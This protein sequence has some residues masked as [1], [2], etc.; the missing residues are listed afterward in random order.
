V[1]ADDDEENFG[2]LLRGYRLSANLTQEDLASR[3]GLS[4]RTISNLEARRTGR[5]YRRTVELL[6]DALRLSEDGRA[7]LISAARGAPPVQTQTEAE[8]ETEGSPAFRPA[9]LP[10]DIAEFTGRAEQVDWVTGF[11]GGTEGPRPVKVAAVTGAGGLGKSALALHVAHRLSGVFP[12][13]Q[14]F[15]DLQSSGDQPVSAGEALARLLRHLGMA[16]AAVPGDVAERAAEF[17]TRMAGLSMLLVLDDARDAAHVRPLLP[18]GAPSAVLITSRGWLADLEGARVLALEALDHADARNLFATICGPERVA[19]EPEATDAVLEVCGGLPLA[20]RIAAARL[21]SR[22]GWQVASLARRLDDERHRLEELQVGDLAVRACFHVSYSALRQSAAPADDVSRA[23][24][25]LGLWPGT[26]ISLAAA[27]ALLGIDDRAASAL[28]ERLVD[29]HMIESPALYRYRFHDLIRVFAAERAQFDELPELREQA[30]KRVLLWYLH[31]AADAFSVIGL[32]PRRASVPDAEPGIRSPGFGD[33]A[34]ATS[35][36]D[37]E[38]DNLVSAVTLAKASDLDELCVWLADVTWQNF[39]RTPWDGWIGVLDLG[40]SSAAAIGDASAEAWLRNYVGVTSMYR[41]LFQDAVGHFR[42]ALPL[43]VQAGDLNCEVT[44]TA[45]LGTAY[46][47]LRRFDESIAQFERSLAADPDQPHLGQ[48]MVNLGMAYVEAGRAE[49]G[50]DRLEAGLAAIR[51]AGDSWG[52]SFARSGL[53]EGYRA[54]GR[55]EDAIRQAEQALAFG[56]KFRNDYQELFALNTLGE[57]LADYGDLE[58]ARSCLISAR[59]LAEKFGVPELER[60]TASLA[61][62]ENARADRNLA[63]PIPARTFP[64]RLRGPRLTARTSW[65]SRGKPKGSGNQRARLIRDG[66]S[67]PASGPAGQPAGSLRSGPGEDRAEP[68]QLRGGAAERELVAFRGGEVAVQGM[69]DV[70]AYPAV[71]VDG[72]V[73]DPVTA[74]GGPELRGRDLGLGGQAGFQPPRGLPHGQPDRLDVDVS[75]GQ[76]LRHG[77]ERADGPAEGLAALGVLGGLLERPLGHAELQRAEPGRR[78]VEQPGKHL[79]VR[80][81]DQ[82]VIADLDVGEAEPR[83]TGPV[84]ESLRLDFDPAVLALDR[85]DGGAFR[86]RSADQ[87]QAGDRPER[88]CGLGAVQAPA[89]ARALGAGTRTD[90]VVADGFGEGG[91]DDQLTTCGC[92]CVTIWMIGKG[93]RAEHDGFQVGSGCEGAPELDQDRALL[94]QPVAVAADAFRQRGGEDAG[95]GQVGP[96]RFVE[97]AARALELGQPVG[98]QP[99]GQDPAAQR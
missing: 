85:E 86:C 75:V 78:P 6:A 96:D 54:L 59:Q 25:L 88:H 94:G 81:A 91:G 63:G 53:A 80:R 56:R 68:E 30:R 84:D 46:K 45:N 55:Y 37:T 14:L 97:A 32:R 74:V 15:V 87:E 34:A 57:V 95:R 24:R 99:V 62:I 64:V 33:Q 18:G 82:P 69:A 16:D 40:M 29:V 31:S 2:A 67:S 58:R 51:A 35:W 20:I 65:R 27:A 44:V 79:P 41:G 49:E 90:K 23:F 73:R 66:F 12:D 17:R 98:R 28:L 4:A 89:A 61:A 43:G 39:M 72:G 92:R 13:G 26:E 7:E 10:P 76:P 70:D 36:L 50:V 77:L 42:L 83:G 19:A 48:V 60:I 22:P 9:Q 38:R 21:V 93:A 8:A 71:H 47:E 5:P 52:E 11:L 3:A 1:R